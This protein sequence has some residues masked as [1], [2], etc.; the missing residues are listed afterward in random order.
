MPD[1]TAV[2]ELRRRWT[3]GTT[4]LVLDPVELLERLA[5]L[6]PR[7]RT[8]LILYYGVL[9]PRAAW[10][11]AVVPFREDAQGPQGCVTCEGNRPARPHNVPM[12]PRGERSGD[13]FIGES[14]DRVRSRRR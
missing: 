1:G 4:H 14:D 10:R 7:P 3:D 5:A 12:H 6:T 9:A 2:L 13:L 8:N 11:R